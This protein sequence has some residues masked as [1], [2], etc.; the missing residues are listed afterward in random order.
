MSFNTLSFFVFFP[1]CAVAY[2]RVPGKYQNAVLL[3][4]SWLFYAFATPAWLPV[5]IADSL[6]T[7]GA[8]R[9]MARAEGPSRKR[10][11]WLAIGLNLGLLVGLKALAVALAGMPMVQP[12]LNVLERI[13]LSASAQR[14]SLILP[15]GISFFTLQAI[16]CAVDVYRKTCPAPKS[17]VQFCLFTSFF[18]FI[19]SGPITRAGSFLPQLAAP[20][21][22]H[23]DKAASGLVLMAQGLVAKVCVA[24]LLAILANGVWGSG[25]GAVRAWS[26]PVLTLGALAY[27]FQLYFDFSGYSMLAQG[28]ARVLGLE[29]AQNFNT[30]YFSRSIKEFWRRWHMSLSSWLRDYVYIPLGGNRK[31]TVRKYVNVLLTFAMSGLWHGTGF[32]F[33]IWG[34]LHGLYQ[35]VG[36]VLEP[37]RARLYALLHIRR[38]GWAAS[39]W[40]CCITFLLV[41]VAWVFFRAPSVQ[42]ALYALTAQFAGGSVSSALAQAWG[43]ILSGFNAK[44][45]LAAAFAAFLAVCFAACFALDLVRRFSSHSVQG[46]ATP[47]LMSLGT[48]LRWLCYYALAGLIFLG[49]LFNNGYLTGAV[50]FLYANF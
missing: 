20:R 9:W 48:G 32:T 36:A 31:G 16:G 43:I 28:C 2:F 23:A 50:S 27:T 22:F 15:L 33:L 47:A 4:A 29:L 41:H 30:P 21:T 46:E 34:L 17:A 5:L 26:G 12:V 37:L 7:F 42:D 1:L 14:F 8:V 11:L 19:S 10:R 18:G 49:F 6:A 39:I 35:V 38:D 3:A 40:Q 24:D 13:G 45:L 44:P 25:A